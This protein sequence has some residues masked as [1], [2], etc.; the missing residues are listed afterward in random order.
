MLLLARSYKTERTKYHRTS[1][2]R[3]LASDRGMNGMKRGRNVPMFDSFHVFHYIISLYFFQAVV[4]GAD[5]SLYIER[6]KR[7]ANSMDFSAWRWHGVYVPLWPCH[8]ADKQSDISREDFFCLWS[9]L[10][11]KVARQTRY[12]Q[13]GERSQELCNKW[14]IIATMSISFDVILYH[15][16]LW[17]ILD[18]LTRFA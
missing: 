18:I 6:W 2:L 16:W 5:S 8:R 3:Y 12:Q 17:C 13:S 4:I 14:E 15:Y 11:C 9:L 1:R 10:R 7:F